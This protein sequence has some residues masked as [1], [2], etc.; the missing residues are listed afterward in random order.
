MGFW[1]GF[2]YGE[3]WGEIDENQEKVDSLCGCVEC[4]KLGQIF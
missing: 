1:G 2:V 4:M 3:L